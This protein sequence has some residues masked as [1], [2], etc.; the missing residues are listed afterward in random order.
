MLGKFAA[1]LGPVMVG[2]VSALSGDPRTGIVSVLVLFLIG[3][4][5]LAK[6]DVAAGEAAALRAGA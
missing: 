3:A 2:W 4:L 5:L 6:V 1:V